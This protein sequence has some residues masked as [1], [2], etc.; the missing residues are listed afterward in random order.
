MVTQSER[1]ERIHDFRI[2]AAAALNEC[3]E[4]IADNGRQSGIDCICKLFEDK[5]F[6]RTYRLG[7]Y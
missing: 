1:I 6:L 3:A 5:E 4:T 7:I 2:M